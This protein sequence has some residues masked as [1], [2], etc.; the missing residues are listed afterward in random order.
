M[1]ELGVIY[2]LAGR[3][4]SYA[5]LDF[6]TDTADPERGAL[7]Q[8]A[9]ERETA[10]ETLLVFFDL[11]WAALENER[12]DALLEDER[13]EF[14]RHHLR[15]ARRYRPHLLSEPEE[16]ILTEKALSARSAWA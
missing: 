11:E 9:Q 16:L 1:P 5:G 14:C 3:A 13:L 7:M 2:E 15:P 12:A 4:G 6:A 8:R 10:I